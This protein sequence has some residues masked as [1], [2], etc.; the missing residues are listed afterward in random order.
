MQFRMLGPLEVV[1][2]DGEPIEVRGAKLKG[3]LVLLA[4]RAGDVVPVGQ[5]VEDLWGDREVRDPANAVQV[6]VSKLRKALQPAG[7][8][9]LLPGRHHS[10]R[11]LASA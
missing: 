7:P 6:L 9:M 3:L 8:P 5:V 4:L 10:G 1:G 11:L 2:D